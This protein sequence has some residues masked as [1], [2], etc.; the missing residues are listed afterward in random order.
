MTDSTT[1]EE[2]PVST[3]HEWYSYVPLSNEKRGVQDDTP[4]PMIRLLHLFP[5][6][7]SDPL[8]CSLIVVEPFVGA[9]LSG[10]VMTQGLIYYEA[11]S[12]VWG[13]VTKTEYLICN[14]KLLEITASL[15]TA[16]RAVRRPE[17]SR[18]LWADGICINQQDMDERASQILL[19]SS[20]YSQ[21]AQVICWLGDD[22]GGHASFTFSLAD[23]FATETKLDSISTDGLATMDAAAFIGGQVG[24]TK[25][26][27][28]TMGR[29][30]ENLLRLLESNIPV[31]IAP[32][33]QRPW[34]SRMWVR[35]EVGYASK[36]LI[37]CRNSEVDCKALHWL[38]VW[39]VLFDEVFG[40]FSLPTRSLSTFESY[41]RAPLV[42]FLELLVECRQFEST[43][44]RDKVFALLSHPSA[45][46]EGKLDG[47]RDYCVDVVA[48]IQKRSGR[49][50]VVHEVAKA[51]AQLH[52]DLHY[53]DVDGSDHDCPWA[54]HSL[55]P[56]MP[57]ETQPTLPCDKK[58]P[59][60]GVHHVSSSFRL[61]IGPTVRSTDNDPTQV[62]PET[63]GHLANIF[64]QS[65]RLDELENP[66]LHPVTESAGDP[67]SL[68]L[69]PGGY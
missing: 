48:A 4:E 53:Y 13:D 50:V 23:R 33:L 43:D 27:L 11:L 39:A 5:G 3:T 34:F 22:D 62:S 67:I 6:T 12:Y 61:G 21:A 17:T 16:L 46:V 25:Q 69:Y 2:S 56:V 60:C 10:R 35:Q 40:S 31:H 52:Q 28:T 58:C 30:G 41:G 32:L 29:G 51:R 37:V 44:P 59:K 64:S 63:I 8:E 19:M 24:Y 54:R 26:I 38:L 45:W 1:E 14:E 49:E 36:A 15:V 47:E 68:R 42:S 57:S 65:R 66:R 55:E 18:T 7:S 9:M 20:I